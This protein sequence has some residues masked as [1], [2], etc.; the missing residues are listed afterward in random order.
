MVLAVRAIYLKTKIGLKIKDYIF[1]MFYYYGIYAGLSLS[2]LFIGK[3]W[4]ITVIG[5]ILTLV[6][7]CLVTIKLKLVNKIKQVIVIFIATAI[8]VVALAAIY[9]VELNGV[10]RGSYNI[11]QTVI[12]SASANLSLFVSLTPGAI[13]FR[14]AFLVMSQALHHISLD[15]IV[16]ANI[17]D[18]AI[19][20]IF[21]GIL[22]IFSS[23]FNLKKMFNAKKN[24]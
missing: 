17:V 24:K 18:R 2:I 22:F 15:S 21:L 5:I 10:A 11:I 19:Y 6:I 20:V 13:G 23:I 16:A 3:S 7:V 4:I 12:Y 9:S 8:Q 1:S 14:E